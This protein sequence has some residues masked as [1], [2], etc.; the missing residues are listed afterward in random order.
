ML[1]K[2]TG[3]SSLLY[4]YKSDYG[5]VWYAVKG[6]FEMAEGY[7]IETSFRCEI[8]FFEVSLISFHTCAYTHILLWAKLVSRR[9]KLEAI[10]NNLINNLSLCTL[11]I[12]HHHPPLAAEH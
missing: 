7:E 6:L 12:L 8:S 1:L 9:G 5:V 3:K 10:H 2:G 4:G 11:H